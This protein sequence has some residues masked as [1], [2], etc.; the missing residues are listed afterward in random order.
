MTTA[1]CSVVQRRADGQQFENITDG[2]GDLGEENL[3]DGHAQPRSPGG[4]LGT[5]EIATV[6]PGEGSTQVAQAQRTL[7]TKFQA[8]AAPIPIRSAM[9]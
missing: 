7:A 3:Q 9:T 5:S 2:M 4:T 1:R 8:V 6:M